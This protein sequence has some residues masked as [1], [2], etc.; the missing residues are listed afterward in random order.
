MKRYNFT[1][2]CDTTV[3]KWMHMLGF[4]YQIYKKNY[5]INS[6]ESTVTLHYLRKFIV[7]YLAMERSMHRWIQ[8]D[9]S[10]KIDLSITFHILY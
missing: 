3:L 10:E 2:I 6:N 7:R 5:Y 1:E 9:K 8:I 4:L